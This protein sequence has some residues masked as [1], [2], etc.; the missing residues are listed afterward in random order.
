MYLRLNDFIDL[1]FPSQYGFRKHYSTQ[2]AVIDIV[3]QIHKNMDNRKF[4]V[5]FL[6]I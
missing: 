1:L 4:S 5:V 3:D 6:L 2:Y